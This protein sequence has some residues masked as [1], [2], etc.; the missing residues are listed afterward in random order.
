MRLTVPTD[1][2]VLEVLSDGRR[3]T[4]ANLAY[5]LDHDRTYLNTRLPQLADYGLVQKVGPSPNSGLYV[6]TE[7]GRIA[8]NNREMY[9]HD[10]VDFDTLVERKTP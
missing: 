1:F 10:D 8:A 7:K 9:E 5:L 2:E 4:A 3:N 6:I